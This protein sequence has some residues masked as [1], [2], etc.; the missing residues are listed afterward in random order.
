MDSISSEHVE[1]QPGLVASA[2]IDEEAYRYYQLDPQSIPA[3]RIEGLIVAAVIFVGS[4][5]GLGVK[6]VAGGFAFDT[7]FL[8]LAGAAIVLCLLLFVLAIVWPPIS[9]RH[10][11]WRLT[12]T[13]FEIKRGV[14][15]RHQIS[16]PTARVQHADVSQG[17]LQRAFD[18]GTLTI[19]TAGTQN[20]SVQIAGLSHATAMGLRDE[21]VRQ[22]KAH[23]VV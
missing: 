12:P 9:F 3:D 13:G 14:I 7:I 18:L 16:I 23:D 6:F 2:G 1:N 5:I 11:H 17:P 4:L 15:W 19:H 22:R 20:S 10:I 21:I 8:L